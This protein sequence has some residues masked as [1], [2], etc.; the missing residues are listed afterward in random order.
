M[1]LI[2]YY[3]FCNTCE[4]TQRKPFSIDLFIKNIN[5]ISSHSNP[6]NRGSILF[7]NFL[8]G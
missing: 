5:F 2:A 6:I 1:Y 7:S 4:Q 8:Q 3:S